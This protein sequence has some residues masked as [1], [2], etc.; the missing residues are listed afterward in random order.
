MN[1]VYTSQQL[2]MWQWSVTEARTRILAGK[3]K[4]VLAV[5][6][7]PSILGYG[8]EVSIICSGRG[9][10]LQ[11]RYWARNQL[12]FFLMLWLVRMNFL[13]RMLML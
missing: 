9:H 4:S 12:L 11:L 1:I 8:Q 7:L 2:K 6:A 13:L 3:M 10:P 5:R